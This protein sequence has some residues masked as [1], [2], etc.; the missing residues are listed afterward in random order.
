V[1]TLVCGSA[2]IKADHDSTGHSL[3]VP[4]H[5]GARLTYGLHFPHRRLILCVATGTGAP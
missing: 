3:R 5:E 2:T 4:R 1:L